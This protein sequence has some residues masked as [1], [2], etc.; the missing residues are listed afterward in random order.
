M[1][2]IPGHRGWRKSFR[3]ARAKQVYSTGL[4]LLLN[5]DLTSPVKYLEKQWNQYHKLTLKKSRKSYKLRTRDRRKLWRPLGVPDRFFVR[6]CRQQAQRRR[7]WL[8]FIFA[9]FSQ[10][11]IFCADFLV[12][13]EDLGILF[14][15]F[16]RFILPAWKQV[17]SC[18]PFHSVPLA[19]EPV[20]FVN[21]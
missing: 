13:G 3:R 9:C 8:L 5:R 20:G 17:I 18:I 11:T 12:L 4:G 19:D 21:I 1:A 2:E 10:S 14:P 7:L 16:F 15:V 6:D